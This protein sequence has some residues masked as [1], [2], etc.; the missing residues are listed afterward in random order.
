MTRSA[1]PQFATADLKLRRAS[2]GRLL[3]LR[4]HRPPVPSLSLLSLADIAWRIP[5]SLKK[6][7]VGQPQFKKQLFFTG[8]TSGLGKAA[9]IDLI[10]SGFRVIVASRSDKKSDLLREA[11]SKEAGDL[12]PRLEIVFCDLASMES[13]VQACEKIEREYGKLDAIINNAGLWSFSREETEDEIEKT[14]QVNLLAPYIIAHRLKDRLKSGGKLIQTASA[15]HQGKLYADDPEF[16]KS[17]SGFRAYR[18]SKLGII[19]LTRWWAKEFADRDIYA[20]SQHPGLV[21]TELGREGNWIV[22]KFFDWFGKSPI[23]GAQTLLFLTKSP[24][25]TLE[26]GAYYKNEKPKSTDTAASKSME[27][28]QKVDELCRSYTKEFLSKK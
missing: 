7:M 2:M 10:K 18:Q 28:A 9:V 16:K 6:N 15:L 17:Y 8:G 12:L 3:A 22:R 5:L 13:I 20:Y 4:L 11:V 26:N 19:L 1:A 27:V 25:D 21:S 23:Q 14:L 24:N